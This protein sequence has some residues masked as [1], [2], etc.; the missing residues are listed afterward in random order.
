MQELV[1]EKQRRINAESNVATITAERDSSH[2]ECAALRLQLAAMQRDLDT[3]H[4]MIN[5]GQACRGRVE[6]PFDEG[7]EGQPSCM[8]YGVQALLSAMDDAPLG[9][10]A[11]AQETGR[12]SAIHLV[13]KL[14]PCG[15]VTL[16]SFVLL[17]RR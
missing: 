17:L 16:S 1:H 4:L 12:S 15:F 14:L 9:S 2:A 7:C 10:D 6:Q 5:E 3:A 8:H 11:T 13:S